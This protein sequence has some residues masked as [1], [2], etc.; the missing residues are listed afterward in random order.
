MK[1][2][3][4][5]AHRA[6]GCIFVSYASPD[7]LIRAPKASLVTTSW[8]GISPPSGGIAS[9][10]AKSSTSRYASMKADRLSQLTSRVLSRKSRLSASPAVISTTV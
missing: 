2:A 7:I 5:L 3:F 1:D 9:P 6:P 4:L 10:I 8:S